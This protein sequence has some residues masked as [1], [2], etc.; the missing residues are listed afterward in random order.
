MVSEESLWR[1]IRRALEKYG[2]KLPEE[3]RTQ[4]Y[5]IYGK[6]HTKLEKRKIRNDV[7]IL[8]KY[9]IEV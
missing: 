2:E 1:R 3:L 9:G 4:F 6:P 5:N 8:E 7:R